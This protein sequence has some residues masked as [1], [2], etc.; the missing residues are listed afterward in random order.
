MLTLS[1]AVSKLSHCDVPV[2]E[3]LSLLMVPVFLKN[4]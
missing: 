3:Q 2:Y 4:V 1:L